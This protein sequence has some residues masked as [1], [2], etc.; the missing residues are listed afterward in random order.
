MVIP[1]KNGIRSCICVIFPLQIKDTVV[2]IQNKRHN[3]RLSCT[4]SLPFFFTLRSRT[5]TAAA[6]CWF[7]YGVARRCCSGADVSGNWSLHFGLIGAARPAAAV[8]AAVFGPAWA[9]AAGPGLR[10]HDGAVV[11]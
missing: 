10:E 1:E 7:T 9:G 2:E 11:L 5:L 3:I 6:P 4:T 8:T